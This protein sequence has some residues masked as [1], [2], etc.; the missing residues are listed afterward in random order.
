MSE[1]KETSGAVGGSDDDDYE[2]DEEFDDDMD[3]FDCGLDDEGQCSL[4]G[5]EDCDF[6][7]PYRDSEDF[8]GSAAWYRKHGEVPPWERPTVSH[9]ERA[10][11]TASPGPSDA[12]RMSAPPTPPTD[13]NTGE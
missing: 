9:Q 3:R 13:T 10:N 4:A 2:D 1:E 8:C 12:A 6:E 7:C 11:P 5:T